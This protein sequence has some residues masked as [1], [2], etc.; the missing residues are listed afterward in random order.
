MIDT[1]KPAR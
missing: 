1:Q